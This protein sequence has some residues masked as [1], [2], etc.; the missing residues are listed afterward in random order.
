MSVCNYLHIALRVE[1][2]SVT[3]TVLNYPD[4]EAPAWERQLVAP[5]AAIKRF[6][7]ATECYVLQQWE[8][9]RCFSLITRNVLRPADGYYMISLFV[10]AGCALTGKQVIALLS[11]LKKALVE[12]GDTSCQAIDRAI[13]AA[14]VPA[15]PMRLQSWAYRPVPADTP[16]RDAAYRTYI[17]SSE[18]AGIFSFPAQPDYDSYR[19]I[20]VVPASASLRPGTKMPRITSPIRKLYTILAPADVELL[21]DT[22]YSGERVTI[23]YTRPGFSPR[24]ETITVGNPSAF[25]RLDGSTIRVRDARECGVRF[26]RRV[27]VEVCS[28]KGGSVT[29]YTIAINGRPVN[30]MEPYVEFTEKDL[31]EYATV[32]IKAASNGFSPL[33]IE[34]STSELLEADNLV[35]ELDPVEQGVTLRLDF[36]D[37]RVVE[38]IIS[39]EKNTPEYTSLRAGR[40]HGHRAHRTVNQDPDDTS[41]IYTVDVSAGAA[42]VREAAAAPL[43]EESAPQPSAPVFENIADEN[44]EPE[45]EAEIDTTVPVVATDDPA[46]EI[47]EA[48]N[49]VKQG[50]SR[51]IRILAVAAAIVVLVVVLVFFIP[52]G[53]TVGESADDLPATVENTDSVTAPATENAGE[54]PA[55]VSTLG[56]DADYLNNN[57]QWVVANLSSPAGNALMNAFAEGD[58]DAIAGNEYF[59]AGTCTNSRARK[60]LELMWRAKTGPTRGSIARELKKAA[61]SGTIDLD[62]LVDRL[63]RVQPQAA[64]ANTMP[65]PTR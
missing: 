23:T 10:D 64:D 22:A 11:E 5:A 6:L 49:N 3:R 16:M 19:C 15:D 60:A 53:K 34:K 65:L 25:I 43:R 18:L 1:A 4:G 37:G 9:G 28:S 2:D 50:S 47:K 32:E 27:P 26:T 55:P 38:Q 42:P 24:T 58:V 30:T 63:A 51:R 61:A 59:A 35:L 48:E 45:P 46:E 54:A 33:K 57:R 13:T 62:K 14:G 21:R 40:F 20:I 39:I 41:E 17:S 36:G 29:G 56:A 7:N 52:L 12:D 44:P 31:T 8:A